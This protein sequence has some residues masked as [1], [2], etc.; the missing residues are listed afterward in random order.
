MKGIYK[1]GISPLIATVLIIGFT[2]ALAA[3]ILTWGTSFTKSISKG[4]E[5]TAELQLTC[6]QDVQFDVKSA[7]YDAVANN[8]RFIVENNGNKD[9]KNFTAR[10]KISDTNVLA[11]ETPAGI[12]R[13][14]LKTYTVTAA[15]DLALTNNLVITG[16]DLDS[17]GNGIP[18]IQD[19]K[20][21]TLVPVINVG[22]KDVTCPQSIDSYA[23]A[24]EGTSLGICE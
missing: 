2:V 23:P 7:C 4:T 20:E 1:K 6:A 18:D 8:I 22:G 3:V 11:G 19:I 10:V 12:A 9:I 17:D 14:G 21:V 5:E 16:I 24:I 13:F 15:E